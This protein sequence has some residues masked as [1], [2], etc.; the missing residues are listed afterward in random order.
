MNIES[1]GFTYGIKWKEYPTLVA[2]ITDPS[3]IFLKGEGR[4]ENTELT[5]TLNS[6]GL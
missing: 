6:D 4:Y 2:P 1:F 5:T 3:V